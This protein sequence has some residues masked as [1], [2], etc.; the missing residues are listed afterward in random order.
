MFF[1]G[2]KYFIEPANQT[3]LL[4][5]SKHI[6]HILH[7]DSGDV[8]DSVDVM[9]GVVGEAGAGDEVKVFEDGVEAFGEAG[10]EFTQWGI[11]VDQKDRL[12]GGGVGHFCVVVER[13]VRRHK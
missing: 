12:V 13:L 6:T 5:H 10:V 3:P 4:N 8:G 11:G 2:C 9:F 1:S 7:H